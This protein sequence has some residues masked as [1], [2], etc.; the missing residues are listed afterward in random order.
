MAR[1]LPRGLA[2]D[3]QALMARLAATRGA[4]APGGEATLPGLTA[5][6][7]VLRGGNPWPVALKVKPADLR[8]PPAVTAA[9]TALGPEPPAP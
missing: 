3:R 1:R 5:S 7:D 8:E 2:P 4:L 6:M 9:R